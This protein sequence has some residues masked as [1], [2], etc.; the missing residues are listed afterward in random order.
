MP[1]SAILSTALTS[2]LSFM[3]TRM[4]R[5]NPALMSGPPYALM[6][7]DVLASDD[8]ADVAYALPRVSLPA[9]VPGI[10]TGCPD[11]NASP[12]MPHSY[13]L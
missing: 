13:F 2:L 5:T 8:S 10:A 4:L 7:R 1:S 9:P 6:V 3:D 12:Q 11:E